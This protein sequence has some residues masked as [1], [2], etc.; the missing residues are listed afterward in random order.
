MHSQ[1]KAWRLRIRQKLEVATRATAPDCPAEVSWIEPGSRDVDQSASVQP[2]THGKSR[3]D[4][5]RM[6]EQLSERLLLPA[7]SRPCS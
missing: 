4:I 2:A 6:R 5:E 7:S 3:E 1:P